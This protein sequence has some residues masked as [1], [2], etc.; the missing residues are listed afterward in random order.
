[1]RILGHHA[2]RPKLV[3]GFAAETQN[4]I[5]NASAKLQRKGADM[6]VANDVSTSTGIGGAQGVMGGTRNRVRLVSHNGVEDWPEMDKDE[7]AAKLA[8]LIAERLI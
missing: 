8:A 3:I 5:E 6:I 7:V 2:Q 4:L 1:L